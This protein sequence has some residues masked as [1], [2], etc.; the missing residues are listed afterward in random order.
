M[1]DRLVSRLSLAVGL[2]MSHSSE[3]SLAAQVA[4]I[5]SKLTRVELSTV[6]KNDGTRDAEVGDDVPLNEPSHFS[7][8]CRGYGLSLYAFAEVV[9][10]HKKVLTLPYTLRE[11]AEDIHSRC[12]ERQGAEDWLHRGGGDSLDGGNF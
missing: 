3:P 5:V 11:R 10:R 1:E 4:E 8:G 2:R 7:G 6:I 12:G 9:D